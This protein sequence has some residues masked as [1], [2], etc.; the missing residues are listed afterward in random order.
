MPP[1]IDR[2]R[3]QEPTA[4]SDE[5]DAMRNHGKEHS[6]RLAVAANAMPLDNTID[7]VQDDDVAQSLAEDDDELKRRVL[8]LQKPLA[9]KQ[10]TRGAVA[11]LLALTKTNAD[12]SQ[13][14]TR[15]RKAQDHGAH[16]LFTLLA[17]ETIATHQSKLGVHRAHS[18]ATNHIIGS[19]AKYDLHMF[20]GRTFNPSTHN[21]AANTPSKPD[22]T[23]PNAV[24]HALSVDTNEAS[25]PEEVNE[26]RALVQSTTHRGT[27]MGLH[28]GLQALRLHAASNDQSVDAW[29]RTLSPSPRQLSQSQS[30]LA[31]EAHITTNA[32]DIARPAPVKPGT[33]QFSDSIDAKTHNGKSASQALEAVTTRTSD[34]RSDR[35]PSTAR[36][37][38]ACETTYHTWPQAENRIKTESKDSHRGPADAN[39][40]VNGPEPTHHSAL[41]ALQTHAE[42]KAQL[43]AQ[44]NVLR[45]PL[46]HMNRSILFG[47]MVTTQNPAESLASSAWRWEGIRRHPLGKSTVASTRK[48]D[49]TSR[50]VHKQAQVLGRASKQRAKPRRSAI[51]PVDANDTADDRQQRR[52]WSSAQ[53]AHANARSRKKPPRSQQG[54]VSHA[55]AH[56]RLRGLDHVHASDACMDPWPSGLSK[57]TADLLTPYPMLLKRLVSAPGDFIDLTPQERE[58]LGL[59][60]SNGMNAP[61]HAQACVVGWQRHHFDAMLHHVAMRKLGFANTTDMRLHLLQAQVHQEVQRQ[62]C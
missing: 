27:P 31:A 28:R 53:V 16:G 14:P 30:Q 6:H 61:G 47:P 62:A 56:H 60:L 23:A 49:A 33:P 8:E 19:E 37:R 13:Q 7:T 57:A 59:W 15:S 45:Q 42:N 48:A 10:D 22:N 38:A 29:P 4:E 40:H 52:P 36:G 20:H 17:A 3:S 58:V 11:K 25:T 21:D 5:A 51:E 34:A 35:D 9:S 18:A 41:D 26:L 43:M 55:K 1:T 32:H 50:N 44:G 24:G 2:S 12:Q 46:R 54:R 39:T